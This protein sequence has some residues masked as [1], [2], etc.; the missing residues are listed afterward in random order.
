[1]IREAYG[2]SVLSYSQVSRWLKAFKAEREEVHND[3][4]SE[5]PPTSKIVR[6]TVHKEFRPEEQIVNTAFYVDVLERLR[7]RVVKT[8]KHISATWI[9]HHDN[10]PC[11]NA[12]RI[13]TPLKGMRFS[14]IKDIQ[15]AATEALK[16]VAENAFQDVYRSWQGRWQKCVQAQGKYFEEF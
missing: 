5:R 14:S 10:A 15:A 16:A 13:K 3:Q 12:L 1:M 8:R 2:D 11:H 9:V 6:Q 7:K 4:R